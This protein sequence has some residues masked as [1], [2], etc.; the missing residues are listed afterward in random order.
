[1]EKENQAKVPPDSHIQK[2]EEIL[3]K[4][5]EIKIIG[6]VSKKAKKEKKSIIH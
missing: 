3:C 6:I 5:D 1:M 4:F 2:C